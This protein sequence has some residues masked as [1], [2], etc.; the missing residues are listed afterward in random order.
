MIQNQLA[1]EAELIAAKK[2]NPYNLI[3]GKDFLLVVK[4]KTRKNKTYEASKFVEAVT[5]FRYMVNGEQ[6]VVT[7]EELVAT[8][9][10]EDT[11]ISKFLKENT[12]DMEKYHYREWTEKTYKDV[13]AFL[14]AIIPYKDFM[15]E[16]IEETRDEKMKELLVAGLN[17]STVTATAA[18]PEAKVEAKV[19][20][21]LDEK[22]K[23]ELEEKSILEQ[24]EETQSQAEPVTEE[25]K[26]EK[27]TPVVEKGTGNEN[28]EFNK[29]LE[30]L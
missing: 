16:L 12:P 2:I 14:K 6:L 27:E 29:M 15:R 7:R 9:K 28:D 21:N 24:A 10:G 11:Q 30:E 17:D 1:P 23:P 4:Q 8:S 25:V 22:I 19:E 5:P 26:E 13:A 20:S 3:E 18:T